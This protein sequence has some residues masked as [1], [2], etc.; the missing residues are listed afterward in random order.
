MPLTIADL[1]NQPGG[2]RPAVVMKYFPAGAPGREKRPS[3]P[4]G[5]G[6]IAITCP[7]MALSATL[8]LVNGGTAAVPTNSTRPDTV[9]PVE[10]VIVRP[11]TSR[12][13]E[14]GTSA[15]SVR[16][17]LGEIGPPPP[18]IAANCGLFARAGGKGCRAGRST[19]MTYC[20]AGTP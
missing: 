7:P 5:D 16:A 6:R 8:T 18:I 12:S 4:T 17:S 15:N 13:T 14:R 20:P 10:R 2:V 3:S 1:T 9:A 11:A 19:F